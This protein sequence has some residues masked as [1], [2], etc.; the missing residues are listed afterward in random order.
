A[1]PVHREAHDRAAP[2]LAVVA[3]LR[4][5]GCRRTR[6]CSRPGRHVGDPRHEVYPAG[7]AAELERS[8]LGPIYLR[9]PEE[10]LSAR[11]PDT[12]TYVA[13][14][15]VAGG[16]HGGNSGHRDSPPEGSESRILLPGRRADRRLVVPAGRATTPRC[17]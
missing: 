5:S 14:A 10:V 15:D 11:R 13:L 2:G 17:Q 4:V 12:P 9:A 3:V 8:S 6:R 1:A 7:P 16:A